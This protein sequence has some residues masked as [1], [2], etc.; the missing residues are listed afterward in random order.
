M[1]GEEVEVARKYGFHWFSLLS[2]ALLH[3]QIY[4]EYLINISVRLATMGKVDYAMFVRIVAVVFSVS[5][6]YWVPTYLHI[7]ENKQLISCVCIMWKKY[8][9]NTMFRWLSWSGCCLYLG[10][11][12]GGP[13]TQVQPSR[14][15]HSTFLNIVWP[16]RNLCDQT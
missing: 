15:P 10:T 6:L 16:K 4:P 14:A 2:F 12:K 5:E 1:I 8:S 3:L 7:H 11:W 13:K 9:I